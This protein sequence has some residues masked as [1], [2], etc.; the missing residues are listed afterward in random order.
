VADPA[1]LQ[2]AIGYQFGDQSL[3]QLALTHC[4]AGS[5]NNER[6][7]F[8]G[9]SIINHIVAEALYQRF[10]ASQ[11]G[12]MS[13]MRAFLVK[14]EMLAEV[15]R[16]MTLGAYVVLGPGE[17]KSGGHRRDSIL[18]D[19]LEALAGAILLDSDV[20]QCRRTV[21]PWF[22]SRLQS[23]SFA[24]AEKDAKT[25]LQEFLQGRNCPLPEYDLLS[26]Q[27]DD[28]AQQFQVVCR[29]SKPHLVVE[30]SGP[31]RRKAE[32]SAASSALERLSSH[33]H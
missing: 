23:L 5:R 8:L 22:E 10:P 32:Q 31:S 33:G 26:V 19:A 15:A 29:I 18:A 28:H 13:R 2:K 9:D 24:A 1:R 27:G 14:G 30:G 7:E 21:L 12:E 25:Q 3:L 20:E 11:E 6:L 16:E 4:S 17:R